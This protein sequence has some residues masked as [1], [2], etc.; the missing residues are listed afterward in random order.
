MPLASS[1][2]DITLNTKKY[3]LIEESYRKKAQQPFNPRFSTGDPA[4]TDL[5][6]WQFIS[7]ETWDGGAGQIVYSTV[8]KI[9]RSS[10]WSF[11]RGKPALSGGDS[12]V[13]S[14]SPT[15]IIDAE[16]SGIGWPY[17]ANILPYGKEAANRPY[18]ILCGKKSDGTTAGTIASLRSPTS[19]LVG[20]KQV[21]GQAAAIWHRSQFT[22]VGGTILG[23]GFNDGAEKY[24]F[25]DHDGTVLDTTALTPTAAGAMV[26]RAAIPVGDT[27][28]MIFGPGDHNGAEGLLFC[29][30]DYGAGNWTEN[31]IY[32]SSSI[33]PEIPS[34][35]LDLDS[36]ATLYVPCISD[37]V[38]PTTELF[39]SSLGLFV[40]ADLLATN[41]PILSSVVPYTD[42]V[43]AGAFALAGTIYLIGAKRRKAGASTYYKTT[44]IKY[45]FTV[46]WESEF[47]STTLDDIF[48]RA[49]HKASI[50]ELYF[51]NQK[52][53]STEAQS[54]MRVNASGLVEEVAA[55]S[56]DATGT[57]KK[58]AALYKF[59]SS[60]Y[61]YDIS[62]NGFRL[63]TIDPSDN[64]AVAS[65]RQLKTSR[66]GGNTPLINKTLYS[67]IVELS[68]AIT[69]GQTL[70][71]KV[72]GTTVGTVV[73]ADGTRKE[74]TLS[75]EITAAYFEPTLEM[76]ST[77][78]WPG[79]IEKV[80]L[81]Y[82]PTQFKKKA[83]A[84]GIRATKNLKRGDGTAATTVTSTVFSDLIAA[85]TSN[86]PITFVDIDGT[87][88]T[89]IVTDFDMRQPLLDRR[90]G[91][92]L[93]ALVFLELLEV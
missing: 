22:S 81:R 15:Q 67:V 6:F 64:L 28:F 53:D 19:S 57:R 78:T 4:L 86:V 31:S 90:G 49:M 61:G 3:I 18:I 8:N 89:V 13:G 93:E 5:S 60:F 70:T 43:I 54:I 82:I 55:F 27:R 50:N 30:L 51:V 7:Q 80:T 23:Y 39:G 42:F 79:T 47:E 11:L 77:A 33:L 52:L 36:S 25:V 76:P 74:I 14:V 29:R 26:A 10:G 56:T 37:V 91:N 46:M 71:V 69:S 68:E 34:P 20:I 84:M 63:A 38:G 66:Y 62:T 41:G 2:G 9:Q 48:P 73:N 32:S 35:F 44:V 40:T 58:V 24:Q 1:T 12:A 16:S 83:W 88:N 72:N 75:T 59:G 92:N 65:T 45:P 21:L 17:I 87:S 85:W